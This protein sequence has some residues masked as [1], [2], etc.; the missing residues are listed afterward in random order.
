M[1]EIIEKCI[2]LTFSLMILGNAFL[3]K[4][5]V[6]TWL[7]PACIFSLFWFG[8]TF[9]PL[10]F[11]FSVPVDSWA[12]VFIWFC[13]LFFSFGGIFFNWKLAFK[14]NSLKN[15]IDGYLNS[16]FLMGIF[17]VSS[18]L[19]C[20]FFYL[21]MLSQGF[22][23]HDMVFNVFETS[24]KYI[25]LRYSETLEP[26][27]FGKLSFVF[28]YLSITTGGLVFGMERSKRRLGAIL[29]MA[30]IPALA[31]MLFQGDKGLLF[32]F[33]VLF[34]AGVLV[35]RIFENKLYI[36]NKAT[37][38]IAIF[39]LL[40]I[41]PAVIISFLSRGLYE[42]DD[43][44][45]VRQRLVSYISSYAFGHLYA[46]SD[47][48]SFAMGGRSVNDYAAYDLSYGFRTFMAF[49]KTLG[50]AREVP[51]GFYDEYYAYGNLL[52]SNIYTIFRGLIMDFGI[53]G[54]LLFMLISGLG[55]HF[56]FYHLLCQK[57]PAI[58]ISIFI[59]MMGYFFTTF[60]ISIFVWNIISLTLILLSIILLCNKYFLRFTAL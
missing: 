57:R 31:S 60:I 51:Q 40:I 53:G 38:K 55:L 46:F 14:K 21:T 48:F 42:S 37:A 5:M 30:F 32:L 43:G 2:A 12:I 36:F 7:F 54:A 44:E 1:I 29:I 23:T 17:C 58:T 47:W 16:R 11:M 41:V 8:Y 10:L 45:Y 50:D 22:S 18:F 19:A 6:G 20:T 26:T 39:S 52:N 9:F 25:N 56:S 4:R 24:A 28:S 13:T 59:F 49:F 35:I 34:F 27:N 33:I 3:V 15:G